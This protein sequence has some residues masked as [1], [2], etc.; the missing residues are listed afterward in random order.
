M[1]A[2]L[3]LE[4]PSQPEYQF[5]ILQ[6][7]SNQIVGFPV[8]QV[9]ICEVGDRAHQFRVVQ[10]GA[11]SDRRITFCFGPES[12][13]SGNAQLCYT[14]SNLVP[15]AGTGGGPGERELRQDGGN[16]LAGLCINHAC[17]H[18][19]LQEPYPVRVLSL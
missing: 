6:L 9:G 18:V 5:D 7:L 10:K 19:R 14:L 4:F 1:N 3:Q 16:R 11:K 15:R 12:A 2:V 17:V 13:G 8:E